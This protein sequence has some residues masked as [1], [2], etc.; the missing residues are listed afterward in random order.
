MKLVAI[1]GTNASHSFNRLLLNFMKRHFAEAADIE[2]CNIA[3]VPMFNEDVPEQDPEPVTRLSRQIVAADGVI[4][5]CPEHNHSVPSALKSVLEW[6][7]YRQHPLNGKPVMIVGASYHPQGSSRAQIH[8]RQ[9]LDSPGV[10]ARVLPGNEFLLGGVK[11]AFDDQGELVDP[12]TI[13]FL[14]QCFADFIDFVRLEQG[15]EQS[16]VLESAGRTKGLQPTGYSSQPEPASTI[17]G[18]QE[19]VQSHAVHWD[20]TYD[21]VVLG[22][23]G[24]GATAARFAADDGATVLLVDSAP[25]GHEGGN[26]RVSGQLVCYGDDEEKLRAYYRAQLGPMDLDEAIVDTY[27]EGMAGMKSY[28][29]QYLDVEPVSSKQLLGADFGMFPEYP[30]FEG[31]DCIDLLLVHEGFFDGALWKI[32]HQK[33]ADRAD[34]IDVWYR[35]PARHLIKADDGRTIAG[36]QIEREHVLRNIRALNGVVLATG[37][38]EN[39]RRMI[40]DYLGAP[41]LAP[42]GSLFNKGAG[43]DLAIEAGAD[44]WHMAN[45]E[46]LGLQ[47]GL[48]FAVPD[49][50]RGPLLVFGYDDLATGSLLTVGD[51]GS[52]YFREDETNRHGHIFDH[53][54][55]RV[56]PAQAHPHLIFDQ[57]KHDEIVHGEHPEVL[58]RAVQADTA[59]QLAELIGADPQTLAKTIER[60]NSF[61]Q[62]G[63]DYEFGRDPET[64]RAFDQGPYYAIAMLQGMLNTQGGPRRNSRA[65]I[66]DPDGC[67]I[68]HLYGAGEL[69]GVCA[70]VYQGGQNIAEC[71]I[72]GKIAGQNA[73]V[74]KQQSGVQASRQ[75][76][77][78]PAMVA[79]NTGQTLG[80]FKSDL[81][82]SQADIPLGPGQFIGRSKAGMGAEITVRVT[83]DDD[84]KLRD[85]EIISQSE[86]GDVAG[87]A[88]QKLPAQMVARDSADVDVISGATVSSN[89]LKAA[90]A[91]ALRQVP[92]R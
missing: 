80:S 62:Q 47:H 49:G 39:N 45:Y 89:A 3:D 60:F 79:T 26:T 24:A 71:L 44:L 9:I 22:F 31:G 58:D 63:T 52:R 70:G 14:E 69:G 13:T 87:E 74:P 33:V 5:G 81:A 66:L 50:E 56:P 32:L 11:D 65:E 7:S 92:G 72:F 27:V 53:G 1:T 68:G 86:T 84:R 2:V 57:E 46:S 18:D 37:G 91:D 77:V 90:V 17:K 38:F 29:R 78:A 48:T 10:S 19:M 20:A 43:V 16:S 82:Q 85:I 88:L 12:G 67:P 64:M 34:A 8:L 76:D 54:I 42:A 30:E 25:E 59:E 55:W 75:D 4:I 40:Q 83:V 21:V 61:V 51:D 6:L 23:G 41:R 15:R 36:V 28:F 73:A 35:S